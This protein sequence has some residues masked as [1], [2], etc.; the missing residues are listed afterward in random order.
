MAPEMFMKKEVG[1]SPGLD[2]WALGCILFALVTG[3]LPFK[4]SK[5]A[6]LKLKIVNDEVEYPAEIAI[7]DE[8][9]DLIY[10]MLDKNPESRAS[11][12]EISDH[13]WMNERQFT[14]EEAQKVAEKYK[15]DAQ[16]RALS[17]KDS[18]QE[19]EEPVAQKKLTLSPK[20]PSP[21][22]AG[23][24][25]NKKPVISGLKKAGA[26]HGMKEEIREPASKP[27]ESNRVHRI[28]PK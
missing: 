9:K 16:K 23:S 22:L 1:A 15:A 4:A 20:K 12:F 25:E 8:L 7:S 21:L 11:T 14:P 10:R 3:I 17:R 27:K 24:P 2:V 13:A 18:D 19:K 5:I 26:G 28:P 6:E